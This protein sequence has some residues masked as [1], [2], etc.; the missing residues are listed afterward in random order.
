MKLLVTL[1]GLI[2]VL[3][4][5][6]YAAFP[7]A[8]QNWLRQLQEA[9]PRRLRLFGTLAVLLGLLLCYLTQRTDVFP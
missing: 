2:L 3:E 4:G 5:L 9:E 1:I 6:P 7:V 8:M